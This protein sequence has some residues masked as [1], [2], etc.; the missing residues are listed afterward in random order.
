MI[1]LSIA[2]IRAVA[3]VA[4]LMIHHHGH[5]TLGLAI[6]VIAFGLQTTDTA[7]ET[8]ARKIRQLE[9]QHQQLAEHLDELRQTPDRL[10]TQKDRSR[11]CD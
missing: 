5:Q 7:P 11:K 3:F 9:N 6:A 8:N 1:R 4:G 2:V 10:R